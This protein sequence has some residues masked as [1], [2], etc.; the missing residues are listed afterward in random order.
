MSNNYEI[1]SK[2]FSDLAGTGRLQIL[3]C[4]KEKDARLSDI[5][6][7]IDSSPQEVYR[8]IVR[9]MKS[10]MIEKTNSNTY[11]L[12]D[13]GQIMFSM[14]AIP[15]F[16]HKT[17]SF[18]DGHTLDDLPPR[19]VR[20]IGALAKCEQISGIT[21]VIEKHDRIYKNAT[22]YIDDIVSESFD[23]MDKVIMDKVFQGIPYRH[24][25]SKDNHLE[26][27]GRAKRLEKLGYYEAI[28]EGKITRK[29]LPTIKFAILINEKEAAIIF[30]SEDDNP[31]LRSM[32]YGDDKTFHGWCQDLFNHY[33][34]KSKKNT[35]ESIP[36]EASL[37]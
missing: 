25:T 13:V 24:I 17:N 14:C 10:K 30:P 29:I 36:I 26:L 7:K 6:K 3:D 20:G 8:N 4:L 18:F 28:S 15:M 22:K 1:I 2:Y 9:L 21:N 11:S 23:S 34:N 16:V 12:T 35:R 37:N 33:W 27:E 31:D 5:A 19:F 32:F